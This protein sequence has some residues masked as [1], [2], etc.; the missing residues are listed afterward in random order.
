MILHCLIY[1]SACGA[2]AVLIDEVIACLRGDFSNV[3]YICPLYKCGCIW[4]ICDL[5]LDQ[6]RFQLGNWKIP[7]SLAW[8]CVA[9]DL[10]PIISISVSWT[11]KSDCTLRSNKSISTACKTIRQNMGE[12]EKQITLERFL[13]YIEPL[14]YLHIFQSQCTRFIIYL[15]S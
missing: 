7:A 14:E 12:K 1:G 13:F 5:D 8:S 15:S 9:R 2:I 6:A 11:G 4:Q 3:S 10:D